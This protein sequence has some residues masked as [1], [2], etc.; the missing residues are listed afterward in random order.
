[1]K[2]IAILLW[3]VALGASAGACGSEKKDDPAVADP[4]VGDTQ[5]DKP[6]AGDQ[7]PA[8]TA[9]Q[10]PSSGTKGPGSWKRITKADE[11]KAIIAGVVH[12]G[13]VYHA[14]KD[15]TFYKT[16]LESGKVETVSRKPDF[17]DIQWLMD[18]GDY[19]VSVEKGGTVYKISSDASREQMGK[20][21]TYKDSIAAATA[22]GKLFTI[23]RDGRFYVTNLADMGY[24]SLKAADYASTNYMM[25]TAGKVVSV[26]KDGSAFNVVT[27]GKGKWFSLGP[28]DLWK[29]SKAATFHGGKPYRV[30]PDGKL[31]VVSWPDGKNTAIGQP[32]FGHV[33]WM[34]STDGSLITL[35]KDGSLYRVEAE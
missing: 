18:A 11:F 28:N 16:D 3:V 32:D 6:P 31:Y 4:K 8:K 1:M 12:S 20:T 27:E 34:G 17:G 22:D 9:D 15:G 10:Q 35:E 5:K 13:A 7:A 23:E 19:M 21:G 24:T 29:G 33:V 14:V 26:E 25:A 2:R 30:G